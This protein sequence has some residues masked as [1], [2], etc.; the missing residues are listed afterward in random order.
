MDR[1]QKA[2]RKFEL[3]SWWDW[4]AC[5]GSTFSADCRKLI[6]ALHYAIY[7]APD[8]R[9]HFRAIW[10]RNWNNTIIQRPPKMISKLIIYWCRISGSNRVEFAVDI[11]MRASAAS[12]G[13]CGIVPIIIVMIPQ[14]THAHTITAIAPS[15]TWV[16]FRFMAGGRN[17]AVWPMMT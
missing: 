11:L 2:K 12:V 15:H 17:I 3:C 14:H 9:A 5:D 7:P 8:D 4:N 10:A 6:S 16:V 1:T 13:I